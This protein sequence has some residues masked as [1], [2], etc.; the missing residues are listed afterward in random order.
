VDLSVRIVTALYGG[1]VEAG[2][3]DT[4]TPFRAP[5][6]R[7][8]LRYWW[9]ATCGAG[10]LY[11]D[12]YGYSWDGKNILGEGRFREWPTL[13]GG[14]AVIGSQRLAWGEC[15]IEIVKLLQEFRQDRVG[16][17]GRSK[18]PEADEISSIRGRWEPRHDPRLHGGCFPRA[19]HGRPIIFHF[20]TPATLATT[21]LAR[22]CRA[23]KA[24]SRM[25]AWPAR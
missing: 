14:R 16:P 10:A 9:R 5:S 2:M 13:K 25:P 17:R 22:N 4:L 21:R 8:H 19:H 1:G 18:W 12:K 15:W 23:K 11:C 7:G 20:K 3:I 6:V 24:T